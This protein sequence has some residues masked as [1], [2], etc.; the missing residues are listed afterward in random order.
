MPDYLFVLGRV[1]DLCRAEAETI[2]QK[3]GISSKKFSSSEVLHIV[4]EKILDPGKLIKILGGTIKIA[5]VFKKVDDKER[6]PDEI[7]NCL[8]DNADEEAKIT[9]GLSAYG[10]ISVNGLAA[11]CEKIKIKLV[12]SG[13]K[14]RF[15]LPADDTELSSVVVRKQK[16][17]VCKQ[18][19]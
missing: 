19:G 6:I 4:T 7:Y 15:V 16:V 14:S 3:E 18:A 2:L 1:R 9:F 10:D 12:S 5:E 13:F 8:K 11:L 17:Q